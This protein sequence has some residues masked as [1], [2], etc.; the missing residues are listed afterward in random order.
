M[1][2]SVTASFNLLTRAGHVVADLASTDVLKGTILY[3]EDAG[4]VA[5]LAETFEQLTKGSLTAVDSADCIRSA[6]EK[7]RR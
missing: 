7:Y 4:N 5:E 6:R 3:D 2:T 1:I